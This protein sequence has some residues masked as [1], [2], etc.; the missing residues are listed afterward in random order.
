MHKFFQEITPHE[1]VTFYLLFIFVRKNKKTVR[2]IYGKR[3]FS[4][5]KKTDT[6]GMPM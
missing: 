4:K 3:L 2:L 5:K 1:T 6:G